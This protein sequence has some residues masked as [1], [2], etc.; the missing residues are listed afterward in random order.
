MNRVGHIHPILLDIWSRPTSVSEPTRRSA[1]GER[2]TVAS[3]KRVEALKRLPLMIPT[4]KVRR[5]R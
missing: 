2:T 1:S 3:M 4:T 5:S